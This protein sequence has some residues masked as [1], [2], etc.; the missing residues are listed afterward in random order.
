MIARYVTCNDVRAARKEVSSTL[1]LFLTFPHPV[2]TFKIRPKYRVFRGG[3][4]RGC[5]SI[6]MKHVPVDEP[7]SLA[8][9]EV[10][11]E[12]V[13][14]LNKAHIAPLTR[15]VDDLRKNLGLTTE[16]PYF[17][18]LDGGIN[19]KVLFVL[20]APGA[21][22]VASGFVSRNNPDESARNM[23]LLLQEAGFNRS[24]T[25]L[26]NIVPWYIGTGKK[27]RPAGLEDIQSGFPYLL[28]VVDRMSDLKGVVLVGKKAGKVK[29]HLTKLLEIPV[30]ETYHPSPLF[31][32]NRPENRSRILAHLREIQ[33]QIF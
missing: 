15:F 4:Y 12:R 26:W 27:I 19:A 32:N 28:Q 17:D 8:N 11:F 25:A 31:V 10:R 6:Q 2:A 30:W 23:F 1:S 3:L 14:M 9:H 7:K 21:K 22:A 5:A 29:H 20:E 24:E 33:S 13:A 18:P 16:I